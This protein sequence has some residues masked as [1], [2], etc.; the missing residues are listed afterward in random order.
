M[1]RSLQSFQGQFV[2]SPQQDVGSLAMV[3]ANSL[4]DL[5]NEVGIALVCGKSTSTIN[6]EKSAML[7]Q[8]VEPGA[9]S[10]NDVIAFNLRV[11]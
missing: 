4:P 2:R 8:P 5:P 3:Y 11:V 6:K 9:G 1:N 7:L 10:D